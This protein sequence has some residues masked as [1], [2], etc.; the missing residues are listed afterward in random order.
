MKELVISVD[1]LQANDPD[2]PEICPNNN[3]LGRWV[4]QFGGFVA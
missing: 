1:S 2:A 4:L 3:C